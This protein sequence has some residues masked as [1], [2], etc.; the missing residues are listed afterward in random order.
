MRF[1]VNVDGT[2]HDKAF[3]EN[4]ILLLVG[5]RASITE[6]EYANHLCRLLNEAV[7]QRR[8][9]IVSL[10]APPDTTP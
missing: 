3:S 10:S 1:S 8:F 6:R 9:H 7:D 2:I 4:T 5:K